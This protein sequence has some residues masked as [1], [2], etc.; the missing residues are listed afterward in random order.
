MACV[1]V[2]KLMVRGRDCPGSANKPL[3]TQALSL[4]VLHRK[5][6]SK[7]TEK[8][9]EAVACCYQDKNKINQMVSVGQGWQ[10]QRFFE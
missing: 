8:G 9:W 10:L 7:E 4:D 1:C 3:T 5:K 6:S 2:Y